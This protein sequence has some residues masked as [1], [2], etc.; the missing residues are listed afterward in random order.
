MTKAADTEVE[1]PAVAQV[2]VSPEKDESGALEA[3]SP[4][5]PVTQPATSPTSNGPSSPVQTTPA[6]ATAVNPKKGA[7]VHKADYEKDVVYLYQFSR[8]PT[9]PSASPFCLK[10]ETWLRMA[11]IKYEVS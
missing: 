1:S 11:G 5:S 6:P 3:A 2:V 10:V 8:F 7:V 9:L 4:E